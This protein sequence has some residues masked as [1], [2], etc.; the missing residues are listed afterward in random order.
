[1]ISVLHQLY[2]Q[3]ILFKTRPIEV[4]AIF[5]TSEQTI[6]T[7]EGAV[8]CQIG[9]AILTGV[10]GERWPVKKENFSYKYEPC[11]GQKSG[12]PGR[13]RKI[14]TTV[15]ASKLDSAIDIQLSNGRQGTL[16]GTV[17]DWCVW[18]TKDDV[19]IVRNDIFLKSYELAAVPVYFCINKEI[20]PAD[21]EILYASR[22]EFK[23]ILPNTP[24]AF[25]DEE[26]NK[27]LGSIS[28]FHIV[29]QEEKDNEI[30]SADLEIP[31]A[32]FF[33][34]QDSKSTLFSLLAQKNKVGVLA[35]TKLKILGTAAMML[36]V[37]RS[38]INNGDL[39]SVAA[40]QLNAVEEFNIQ[41][42]RPYTPED[43]QHFIENRNVAL[44]PL[45]S[46][47]ICEIG[48][49]ADHLAGKNQNLWQNLLFATTKDIVSK[50]AQNN[51][52]SGLFRGLKF[53]KNIGLVFL[54]VFAAIG[55]ASF[56]ELSGGCEASDPFS[57]LGCSSELWKNWFSPFSFFCLYISPLTFAWWKYAHAK[58]NKL[59]SKHQDYRLFS[60]YI[61]VFYFWEI[62]NNG[63]YNKI[64]PSTEIPSESNWVLSALR[65]IFYAQTLEG[66]IVDKSVDR[67]S[68]VLEHFV[69][70]QAKY[71]RDTLIKRREQ[72]AAVLTST[73][74][75]GFFLFL[76]S[77][78][79]MTAYVTA[80]SL[81]QLTI[82]SPMGFHFVLILQVAGLAFWGGMRKVL[83]IF[84][85]EQEIQRGKFVLSA[86]RR[87]E[88]S[89]CPESIKN[90]LQVFLGD[91]MEWHALH[92]NKPIE[93][94][95]GG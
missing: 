2:F 94:T 54:G 61:R 28:W 72:A 93:A 62:L 92:R 56:S 13:Y 80:E 31:L 18:Y 91:Q 7:L 81:L 83:D 44:E 78:L 84:A 76:I 68:Y 25:I 58:S 75:K 46:A 37:R 42:K 3:S 41:I 1:M 49:I 47:R 26:T 9:D 63:S 5:A 64:M 55:I 89:G 51:L 33:D 30:I 40:A 59:E 67:T 39:T 50:S 71:H 77:L 32:A 70:H 17:G 38:I 35:F 82:L 20:T 53:I 19:A 10:I 85:L 65:S 87:A 21:K 4:H 88:K 15:Q 90:A 23:K 79:I 24:I 29:K 60:E 73:G 48:S 12:E 6:E 45:G 14:T 74:H 11:S 86:L 16:H 27:E 36:P 95:T 57:F 22:D 34:S 43:L 66:A 8:Q 69:K 52:V